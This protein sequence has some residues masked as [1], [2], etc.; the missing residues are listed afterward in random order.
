M[1]PK[2]H[3][4]PCVLLREMIKQFD[5]HCEK[6]N[7][8]LQRIW[9]ALDDLTSRF[10]AFQIEVVKG[11]PSWTVSIVITMLTS[12]VVGLIVYVVTHV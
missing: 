10:S 7:G 11:R 6:Q 12:A 1:P 2:P 5:A 8:N 9:E 3:T 4:D